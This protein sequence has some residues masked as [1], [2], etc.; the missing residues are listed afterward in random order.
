MEQKTSSLFQK[1][2]IISFGKVF[3]RISALFVIIYLSYQLPKQDYGSYRQVWLLFNMFVPI[4]SL[5]IPISVN[6]FFPLL[7]SEEKKTFI[8]LLE[9]HLTNAKRFFNNQRINLSTKGIMHHFDLLLGCRRGRSGS[10]SGDAWPGLQ[11]RRRCLGLPL[12]CL[13]H[14]RRH[15]QS[16]GYF[17]SHTLSV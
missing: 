2:F 6:Y 16:L 10:G 7:R 8:F 13:P 17:T 5:G 12:P 3:N 14:L 11:G 1:A 9:G 4:L 15:L